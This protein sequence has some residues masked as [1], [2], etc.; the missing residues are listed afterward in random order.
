MEVELSL[1]SV[2][3]SCASWPGLQARPPAASPGPLQLLPMALLAADGEALQCI[4]STSAK[5]RLLSSKSDHVS[6]PASS[7]AWTPHGAF[8]MA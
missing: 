7:M 2:H 5:V 4:L 6:S 3:L 8:L 1:G